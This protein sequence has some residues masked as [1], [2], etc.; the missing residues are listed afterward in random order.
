MAFIEKFI[1]NRF[2]EIIFTF[3]V[4]WIGLVAFGFIMS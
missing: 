2:T 4:M 1:V 3:A